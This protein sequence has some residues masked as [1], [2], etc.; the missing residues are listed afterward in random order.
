[1]P[2]CLMVEGQEGVTWVNGCVLSAA[3]RTPGSLVGT[4]EEVAQQLGEL[5]SVG[6]S[7]VFVRQADSSDLGEIALF[8]RLAR[9]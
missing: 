6:I 1:M 8:G 2:I 4:L 7:R 5:E 9:R 3:S